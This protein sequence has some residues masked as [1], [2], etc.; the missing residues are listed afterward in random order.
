MGA[1]GGLVRGW[2]ARLSDKERDVGQPLT[3]PPWSG[4]PLLKF[5]GGLAF[6]SRCSLGEEGSMR[7]C[8]ICG[9]H[10]EKNSCL[11]REPLHSPDTNQ[12]RSQGGLG[13]NQQQCSPPA[14]ILGTA[15]PATTCPQPAEQAKEMGGGGWGTVLE[16][17]HTFVKLLNGQEYHSQL[18]SWWCLKSAV[19]E[20][21]NA[22]N[23]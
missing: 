13:V 17:A 18:T 15:R 5:L 3:S 14:G 16:P 4:V 7:R 21:T 8:D 10:Q 19:V 11:R 6:A 20:I 12:E 9:K 22:T 23:K 1:K 2:M